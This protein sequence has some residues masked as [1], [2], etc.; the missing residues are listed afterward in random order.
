MTFND[1]NVTV[2]AECMTVAQAAAALDNN[3]HYV[4]KLCATG[5]LLAFDF[6][7]VWHISREAVEAR[8]AE[9]SA[10]KAV[11]V[12]IVQLDAEYAEKR[13][14]LEAQLEA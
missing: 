7:G 3:E 2:V 8:S 4:R 11:R 6:G 9:T 5:K 13:A 12:Q 14:Q 1:V 10:K